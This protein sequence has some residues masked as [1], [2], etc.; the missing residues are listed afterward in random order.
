MQRKEK[1]I[2]IAV[3]KVIEAFKDSRYPL[4]A[5]YYFPL[6]SEETPEV[7]EKIAIR[8]PPVL[9]SIFTPPPHNVNRL[10]DALKDYH[11]CPGIELIVIQKSYQYHGVFNLLVSALLDIPTTKAVTIHNVLNENFNRY[12][13][14]SQRW[15]P[16]VNSKYFTILNT[17][18][19]TKE[20]FEK[21]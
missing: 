19:T 3:D 4:H 7:I 12:L 13:Q 14:R 21:T 5:F 20:L 18:Y 8:M 1:D 6:L 11:A 15:K 16:L 9:P 2:K 17:F 10:D